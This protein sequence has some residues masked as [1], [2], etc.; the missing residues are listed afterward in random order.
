MISLPGFARRNEEAHMITST[1]TARIVIAVTAALVLAFAR[2]RDA[3]AAF[4]PLTCPSDSDN[5]NM[6]IELGGTRFDRQPGTANYNNNENYTWTLM[7][8]PNVTQIRLDTAGFVTEANYDYLKVFYAAS[9]PFV[10]TGTVGR[11][12]YVFGTK[13][14]ATN[15][16]TID[17]QWF[18]DISVTGQ[19]AYFKSA[20][21]RCAG[22]NAAVNSLSL[23][24]KGMAEGILIGAHD[25]I[26]LST[27]QP[28]FTPVQI[29]LEGLRAAAGADFDL[30]AS[31]TTALPDQITATWSSALGTPNEFL[32]IPAAA[33]ARTIYIAVY[34]YAGN[35]HFSI[36]A[37]DQNGS[38]ASRL[39][40]CTPGF[41]IDPASPRYQVLA[42]TLKNTSL[43][44]LTASRGNLWISGYDI[45]Q[46]PPC[47]ATCGQNTTDRFCNLCDSTCKIC[48]ADSSDPDNCTIGQSCVGSVNSTRVANILCPQ[49]LNTS[50]ADV[51]N[52][53]AAWAHELGHSQAGLPDEY[54]GGNTSF[55]GHTMMSGP[56]NFWC[57]AF[58]HC[59]DGIA[60]PN[61]NEPKCAAGKDNWSLV[62]AGW[63]RPAPSTSTEPDVEIFSNWNQ[64]AM[65]AVEVVVH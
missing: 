42:Q 34:A 53:A 2:P 62:P 35:G 7:M 19:P 47:L 61:A 8:N 65:D 46:T 31:T 23:P 33:T 50:M 57:S 28:A 29:S 51:Q 56:T 6:Q 36:H 52:G 38:A 54:Y 40:V 3:A 13:G 5:S 20:A 18:T 16:K 10:F 30:F 26:Y 25:V 41:R 45:Y 48:V 24:R 39:K 37:T 27:P 58:S 21:F 15:E 43:R 22:S 11:G 1:S 64:T 44:M 9:Q 14:S 32:T 12:S 59:K 55:C 17:V 60:P 63:A 49:Y 4:A